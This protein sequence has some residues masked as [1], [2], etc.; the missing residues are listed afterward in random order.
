MLEEGDMRSTKAKGIVFSGE[1]VASQF[2]GIAWV[3]KQIKE[4]LGFDPCLGT[5]NVRL[6]EREAELL[7][8]FLKNC[9]GIEITPAKGFFR[10]R[11]FKALIM[12]RIRGAVVIPEKP[13][14]QSNVLEIIAPV[15]LRKALSLVDSDEVE[16]T[17]FLD[18]DSHAL[19]PNAV[20]FHKNF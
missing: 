16:I 10:A 6:P 15:C 7:E 14:Y 1:G 9:E 18:I 4:K 8:R 13:N 20:S 12:N 11:C 17:I 19:R 5:L 2:V 3:K